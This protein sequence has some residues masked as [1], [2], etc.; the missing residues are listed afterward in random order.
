MGVIDSSCS[1]RAIWGKE[2]VE[3][4]RGRA[5]A[6]QTS[7]RDGAIV[8]GRFSGLMLALALL[9]GCD[10]KPTPPAGS[11]GPRA[12]AARDF[13]GGTTGGIAGQVSWSGPRPV[14]APFRSIENPLTDQAPP[15]ARDWANPN[16]PVIDSAGGVG[17]AVVFLRGVDPRRGRA[18]DHA[19]VRVEF[20]QHRL[21]V[22]Q[23]GKERSIGVVRAG[24]EIEMVSRQ[25]VYHV[26]QGRGADFFAR[27]FPLP[28]QVRRRR[29]PTSGGSETAR[30]PGV[31]ELLSGAGH[32]WMRGYLLVDEHPYYAFCDPQGRFSLD[33]VP[34]GE[35]DLV[36]WHPSWQV[37]RQER[38]P[39]FVRVQQVRFATPLERVSKVRVETGKVTPA[40]L[41]LGSV[42]ATGEPGRP[43]P[44]E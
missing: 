40:R 22:V 25:E 18:W 8:Q 43:S 15:P 31:V 16:V 4:E 9:A 35:Y 24:D 39:E 27:A 41:E 42:P 38:H 36:A 13:E 2:D 21:H 29:L 14:V 30:A 10:E 44:P 7:S 37:V 12:D 32:F 3:Q 34:P 33:R 6:R 20:R 5:P 23:G 19:P 28:D 26:L 17:S 1:A 11:P